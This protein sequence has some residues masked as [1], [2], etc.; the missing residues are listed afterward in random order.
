[1]GTQVQEIIFVAVLTCPL[2]VIFFFF[3]NILSQTQGKYLSLFT[4]TLFLYR[5]QQ[6]L[7]SS[8]VS[9]L[10]LCQ[11]SPFCFGSFLP[12]LF[13]LLFLQSF[14]FCQAFLYNMNMVRFDMEDLHYKAEHT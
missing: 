12:L 6:L 3:L 5:L 4:P 8:A 11:Q 13:F 1:M 14:F 2:H 9:L 10:F 7:R